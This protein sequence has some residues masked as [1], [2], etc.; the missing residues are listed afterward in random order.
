EVDYCLVKDI[1]FAEVTGDQSGFAGAGVGAGQGPAATF[2][3]KD[4]FRR[5]ERLDG[6]L[7]F[8]V[9]ELANVEFPP[10]TP[11]RPAEKNV[12]GRLHEPVPLHH[13][14]AVVGINALACIGL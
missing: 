11:F 4:H 13:P 12:A 10:E 2:G 1:A 9:A 6:E 3:K 5:L 8:R 7:D 14:L